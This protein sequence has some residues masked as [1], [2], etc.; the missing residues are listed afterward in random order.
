[1]KM[2]ELRAIN[3]EAANYLENIDSK[4]WAT[5]FYAGPYCGHKTSNVVESTNKVF[6]QDRELSILDLLK[7]IW[8]YTMDKRF[9]RHQKSIGFLNNNRLHTDFANKIMRINDTWAESNTTSI[10]STS[11]GI[12]TQSNHSTFT[13]NLRLRICS[14]GHFQENYIPCGHAV[15]F[16]RAVQATSQASLPNPRDYVPYC[17]T[18][19]AYRQT[20]ASNFIAITL[21]HLETEVLQ[22]HL[23]APQLHIS[24]PSRERAALGRPRTVRCTVGGQRKLAKA[25]A[26]LNNR[27]PPPNNGA[28]SQ[29]CTKC[30]LYGHNSIGCESTLEPGGPRPRPE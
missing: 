3:A 8:N 6:K 2:A 13:V 25:Q 22:H 28:G 18:A 19:L 10:S 24:A 5:A 27:T 23:L 1:M 9:K 17:F 26:R 20:Y 12:I 21:D 7:T 15:S 11:E 16:I 4:L 29:S 14:C 30:G